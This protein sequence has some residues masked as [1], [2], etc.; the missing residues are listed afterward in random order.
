MFGGPVRVARQG[1]EPVHFTEQFSDRDLVL[2]NPCGATVYIQ[3]HADMCVVQVEVPTVTNM[4]EP[5]PVAFRP[6]A[7]TSMPVTHACM[8]VLS[9][10][11]H[12]AHHTMHDI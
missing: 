9:C 7:Q 6:R 3:F 10:I 12:V 8:H 4:A 2:G 1:T 5:P 11:A